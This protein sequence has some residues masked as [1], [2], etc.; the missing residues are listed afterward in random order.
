MTPIPSSSISVTKDGV[1]C[2]ITVVI[3]DF[4]FWSILLFKTP[5]SIHYR[6]KTHP[7]QNPW[8]LCRFTRI[9]D[10]SSY[11]W[12]RVLV[13]LLCL[14]GLS[15]TVS[16]AS[17]FSSKLLSFLFLTVL[18]LKVFPV[19]SFIMFLDVSPDHS[20]LNIS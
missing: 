13:R 1:R 2:F 12:F 19:L 11:L 16:L 9:D 3:S 15:R 4:N 5:L 10:R 8:S 6:G 7:T 20:I 14:N 17:V 18:F